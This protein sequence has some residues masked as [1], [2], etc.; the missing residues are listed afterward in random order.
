MDHTYVL[1]A[2][3]DEPLAADHLPAFRA[4]LAEAVGF[5]QEWF[6]NHNND[7]GD[8]RQ[9]HYRYPCVQY[10]LQGHQP[11]LVAIG[12]LALKVR[13]LFEKLQ[14]DLSL[15]GGQRS[16]QVDRLCLQRFPLAVEPGQE[17]PYHYRLID[18]Q[19]LNQQN[20]RSF[21]QLQGLQASIE[22]LHPKLIAHIINFAKGISWNI[23]TR[24][25]VEI[26]EMF[27]SYSRNYKGFRPQL[28]NFA[29]RSNACLPDMIG[30]GKGA[31]LGFGVLRKRR[32]RKALRRDSA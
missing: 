18:W 5:E 1:T 15:M 28:F 27:P 8:Q 22:F 9:L 10:K 13:S 3:F 25:V 12:P 11:V 32:S 31:S 7:P 29:F 21:Q 2:R 30:L 23:E 16:M 14:W 17:L 20:Y 24:L 6:H 19:A 26:T 4:A